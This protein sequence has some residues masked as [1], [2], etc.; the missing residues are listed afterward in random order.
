MGHFLT[1]ITQSTS[2]CRRLNTAVIKRIG[3]DW[4]RVLALLLDDIV[5]FLLVILI[6]KFL[7]VQI[8]LPITIAAALVVGTL[9]FLIH[10]AVIPGLHKRPLT[11][12]E[13]MIGIQGTVVK[14]LTPA[15]T[16]MVN[17]EC[18]SAKSV[19]DNIGADETVEILGLDGLTLKVRRRTLN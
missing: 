16:I 11:G 15:G 18:W 5:V 2:M 12:P 10:R 13:A 1:G 8:P 19:S 4:L 6:L 7:K 17:G 14:P 3:S 9:V